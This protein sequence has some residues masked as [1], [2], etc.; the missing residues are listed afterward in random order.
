MVTS[1]ACRYIGEC[2]IWIAIIFSAQT[3]MLTLYS[4][5]NLKAPTG[6]FSAIKF[7]A[8]NSAQ[9]THPFVMLANSRTGKRVHL[10]LYRMRNWVQSLLR[11]HKISLF[12]FPR[13]KEKGTAQAKSLNWP[14]E[15]K[16]PNWSQWSHLLFPT[17]LQKPTA[18]PQTRSYNVVMGCKHKYP[19]QVETWTF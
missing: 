16:I 5:A 7:M 19:W 2:K 15:C 17:Q 1:W 14:W 8:D 11:C 6:L 13:E 4:T 18:F 12:S 9:T 10:K 3:L